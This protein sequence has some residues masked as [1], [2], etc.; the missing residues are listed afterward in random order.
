[1]GETG[2]LPPANWDILQRSWLLDVASLPSLAP[3]T[4]QSGTLRRNETHY[5]DLVPPYLT[6]HSDPLSLAVI[7][8]DL[9]FSEGAPG[10]DGI[11]VKFAPEGPPTARKRRAPLS[12]GCVALV[13]PPPQPHILES[14]VEVDI[15]TGLPVGD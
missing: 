14:G 5:A 3:P 9:F 13:L 7:P 15:V 4:T 2:E 6:I 11:D 10:A 12:R 8:A 1:V